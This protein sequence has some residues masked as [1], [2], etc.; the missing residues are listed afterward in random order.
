MSMIY[1]RGCG[2][3]IHETAI[4][5]PACGAPQ[6]IQAD[7]NTPAIQKETTHWMTL[8]SFISGLVV[9]LIILTEPDGK[10]DRDTI[11]GAVTLS[12]IPIVFGIIALSNKRHYNKWMSIT[13]IILGALVFLVALGS[14]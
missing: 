7:T 13:G 14:F 11:I 4:T 8:T 2:K 6:N 10:W 5:C 3:S 9:F 1:C 12:L